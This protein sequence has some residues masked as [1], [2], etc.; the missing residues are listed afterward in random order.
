VSGRPSVIGSFGQLPG[1]A[2]ELVLL[3]TA[4]PFL[5]DALTILADVCR[6]MDADAP[7]PGVSEE[8]YQAAL[9]IAEGTLAALPHRR[10]H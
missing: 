5:R 10:G 9:A 2:A 1:T 4:A 6:R 8:E 7:S 3:Q